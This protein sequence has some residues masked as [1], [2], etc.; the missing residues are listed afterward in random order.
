LCEPDVWPSSRWSFG[1]LSSEGRR[2][3]TANRQRERRIYRQASASIR[4]IDNE[5]GKSIVRRPNVRI[6][7]TSSPIS[8]STQAEDQLEAINDDERIPC[9]LLSAIVF[10]II[11][12]R[13]V[14][15][16]KLSCSVTILFFFPSVK[17]NQ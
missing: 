13:L 3:H 1:A 7:V 14:I 5:S 2:E 4:Q 16:E 9:D 12:S 10:S 11:V 6:V 8:F 17:K 15:F